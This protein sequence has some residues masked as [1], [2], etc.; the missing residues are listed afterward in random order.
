[1]PVRRSTLY[2]CLVVLGFLA[3][4]GITSI[5]GNIDKSQV[6]LAAS[7]PKASNLGE[8]TP[9]MS[10]GNETCLKCHGQPGLT[11]TLENGDVL[12]LSVSA[13]GYSASI[14]GK[15]GYAC[16]QCH[17][18]VG[19][20]PHPSWT[21]ASRRDVTITLSTTCNRC[22]SEQSEKAQDSVHGAALASGNKSAAVCA[23]C[24]TGHT[25][26]RLTDPKTGLLST[27]SH[28]LIPQTCA[29]CHNAIYQK[30][31]SSVHGAALIDENNPDV[32]TCISCHGV[33]NIENPTSAYFRLNSPQICAKCH[34]DKKIM[35]KYGIPTDVLT[36][37]V[38]DFHGTTVSVFE[39]QSPDAEVNKAVCFDCHG[40][41]DIQ[42]VDDPVTG[43]QI[44]QN[45][46]QRCKICHPDATTNFPSAWL[47]HYIPTAKNNRVVYFVELFYKLFIPAVLGGM[48]LLVALDFGHS[49]YSRGRKSKPA[50]PSAPLV[51]APVEEVHN[52]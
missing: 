30:Y 33:H 50:P 37:Y 38:A 26:Q 6:A 17:T 31:K 8:P 49:L 43:I 21:A 28:I 3:I 40:I 29:Q 9:Q 10:I 48:G 41:H 47:S 1:M 22:H 15:K 52:E 18:L 42:R 14:H 12:D 51:Q 19:D 46:L 45:L 16:V 2:I 13:N 25:V 5:S 44:K 20:Y 39:K 11:M 7:F 35:G 36:T 34:T 23:D 24:H 4:I 27:S 32:P